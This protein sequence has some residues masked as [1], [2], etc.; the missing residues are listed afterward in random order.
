MRFTPIAFALQAVC[1]LAAQVIVSSPA[2]ITHHVQIQP[3]RV[4]KTNG[5]AATTFGTGTT[6]TYIKDQ[7]NR[8]W[9]QV[10]V[11]ITWL[12]MVDYTNNF[13]YDGA[14]TSYAT[15]VRPDTHLEEIV[16]SAGVP[17]KSGNAIV[18]NLF[19]VEVVPGFAQRND[20][21]ANGLAF[22]DSNG[23]TM[24]VGTELLTWQAGRDVV[25]SVAAHEIGHNLGLI[26]AEGQPTNL[27]SSNGTED[28]LT[29]A[30]KTTIFANRSGTDSYEFLQQAATS[31]H[32]QQWAATHAVTGGPEDDQD[33]DGIVN[34][35]EFMLGLNP[36][37]FSKL[38]TP[39]VG[40]NGLTWTLAK[41]A[42]ALADGLVYR[43][44]SGSGE[45]WL[46]AGT[47]GSGSTVVQNNATSLVV[48]L[49]S[50]GGRR[51]MRMNVDVPMALSSG[52]AAAAFYPPEEEPAPRVVSDCGHAGCGIHTVA[53]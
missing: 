40:A 19:F 36:K 27:M 15:T 12:P 21:T 9:A 26:H 29:S 22:V 52:A 28:R 39:V 18:L 5:V 6:E 31:S 34:V 20:N 53:P 2:A 44:E 48:R 35:I 1:P 8:V 7:I 23:I 14:P 43:V 42:N 38:P 17:P 51:F 37:V 25:A 41:N 50:G 24:H 30:Q 13:A 16:D 10:G 49:N 32:Y 33:K 4:K 47:A 45:T 11:Q 46:T 3:I